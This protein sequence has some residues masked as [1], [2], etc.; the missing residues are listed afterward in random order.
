MIEAYWDWFC[1]LVYWI[2]LIYFHETC[3]CVLPK[4]V[5]EWRENATAKHLTWVTMIHK[6]FT[7]YDRVNLVDIIGFLKESREKKRRKKKWLLFVYGW[8]IWKIDLWR[9]ILSFFVFARII[10]PCTFVSAG[11]KIRFLAKISQNGKKR[12]TFRVF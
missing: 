8:S 5:F 7:D 10:K 3:V 4:T 1:L 2:K 9:L 12:P 6:H 11:S